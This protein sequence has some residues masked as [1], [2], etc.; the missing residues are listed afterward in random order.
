V[1]AKGNFLESLAVP[2]VYFL[3]RLM[4]LLDNI[5]GEGV[6]H[7]SR[8]I[9]FAE[10]SKEWSSFGAYLRQG[11]NE[12]TRLAVEANIAEWGSPPTWNEHIRKFQE[13]GLSRLRL[14]FTTPQ[15]LGQDAAMQ[16]FTYVQRLRNVDAWGEELH[17]TDSGKADGSQL[18]LDGIFYQGAGVFIAYDEYGDPDTRHV[19]VKRNGDD[20]PIWE[21]LQTA[22]DLAGRR[23][24]QL[25][26]PPMSTVA[27]GLAWN[28][29]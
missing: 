17:W 6:A 14:Q 9:D 8:F 27:S 12:D 13:R 3:E 28:V 23:D 15:E 25:L 18:P 21:Q 2:N 10:W 16:L 4:P 29:H 11:W 1:V 26:L 20:N 19:S 24:A 22:I 5:E 7:L